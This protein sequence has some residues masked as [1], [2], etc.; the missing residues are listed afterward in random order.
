MTVRAKDSNNEYDSV[1]NIKRDL[2]MLARVILDNPDIAVLILDPIT[3]YLGGANLNKDEEIRPLMNKLIAIGQRT[4][5]TIL[6]LVHSNK[7]SDV[8]AVEKVM[9]AS[10]V[11]AGARAVWTIAR[12]A[13]D[14][15]LFRMGLAKGNVVRKRT[16]FEYRIVG[17]PVEINGKMCDCPKL[18]WEKETDMDANDMLAADRD[19]S[20]NGGED[21]KLS[22]AVAVIRETVPGFAKDALIRAENEGI[23]KR[24]L[25]R[26]K[27]KL[28]VETDQ[29]RGRGKAWWYIPGEKGDPALKPVITET[30]IPE[31]VFA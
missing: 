13:D 11:S 16:G 29:S 6:A 2:E 9:G 1:I 7:R 12:D 31:E 23:H 22:L 20:R 28:G 8:D 5:L 19:K 27:E 21:S 17:T 3:S 15:E 26:A 24:T 4:G 10:S 18:K 25:F 14:K 30:F